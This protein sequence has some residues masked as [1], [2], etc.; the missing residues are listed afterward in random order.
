MLPALIA[1]L[2]LVAQQPCDSVLA[3][4]NVA[5]VPMDSARV[6]P[7]RTVLV[8]AGRIAAVSPAGA[9]P[10][11]GCGIVVDGSGKYLAGPRRHARPCARHNRFR[12]VEFRP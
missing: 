12:V 6:L 7:N 1:V 9:R 4:W 3:I 11:P 10:A 2:S 8:R 5:V